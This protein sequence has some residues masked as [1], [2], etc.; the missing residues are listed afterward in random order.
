MGRDVSAIVGEGARAFG[1][2]RTLEGV[3][4]GGS[5]RLVSMALPPEAG[6]GARSG[7]ARLVAFALDADRIRVVEVESGREV[8]E[9]VNARDEEA[10][11][12][13]DVSRDGQHVVYASASA[14]SLHLC[15]FAPL[16]LDPAAAAARPRRSRSKNLS[17][18]RGQWHERRSWKAHTRPILDVALLPP[19]A[20]PPQRQLDAD[21]DS[22]QQPHQQQQQQHDEWRGVRPAPPLVASGASDG[23]VRVWDISAEGSTAAAASHQYAAHAGPV[24]RLV[25]HPD[26][27][28][29]VL[30]SAGDDGAVRLWDLLDKKAC[31]T[32]SQHLSAATGLALSSDGAV[33]VSVSRDR[34]VNVW[35]TAAPTPTLLKEVPVFESLEAVAFVPASWLGLADARS[36][37]HFA[38][39]GDSGAIR[40]WRF[41]HEPEAASAAGASTPYTW[42]A[43]LQLSLR[44]SSSKRAEHSAANLV[45]ALHA[46][47]ST[48]QLVALAADHDMFVVDVVPAHGQ[49]PPALSL[50]STIVGSLDQILDLRY[51]L[52]D[53]SHIAVATNSEKVSIDA[54][55]YPYS[56]MLTHHLLAISLS[57][58]EDL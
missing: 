9:I 16:D 50:K 19:L 18:H 4:Q 30:F 57:L 47:P 46:S 8:G 33:L 38:T 10:I 39:G 12:A 54:H 17:G 15:S 45:A 55:L 6:A 53:A 49:Q 7:R 34:V 44:S 11:S 31:R 35:R 32:L 1:L 37:W 28:R 29:M 26:A 23:T 52:P 5:V 24:T 22:E 40:V 27:D 25:F 3:A 43:A 56:L 21:A 51:A 48:H 58:G 2:E 14:C 13:F 41:A 20:P 42:S 36:V